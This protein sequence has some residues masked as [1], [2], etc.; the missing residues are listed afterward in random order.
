M[1]RFFEIC[2][3]GIV[4]IA[5]ETCFITFRNR[6]QYFFRDLAIIFIQRIVLNALK[7]EKGNKLSKR[8][9]FQN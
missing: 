6:F 8:K 3:K 9:K 4:Y 7:K 5:L 1:I 2:S